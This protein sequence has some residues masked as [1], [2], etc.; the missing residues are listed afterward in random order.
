MAN[1]IPQKNAFDVAARYH[2]WLTRFA[3]Y[4]C[5]FS[6]TSTVLSFFAFYSYF[7][8]FVAVISVIALLVISFL[9]VRFRSTYRD[10]EK[11]RRDSL[12]DSS[13][14]TKIAEVEA[15]GYYANTDINTGFRKLLSAIHES[16]SLSLEIIEAMARKQEAFTLIGCAVVI[17][18]CAASS[19]QSTLFLAILN[20][21]L[22]LNMISDYLELRYLRTEIR[23]VCDNCKHICEDHCSTH[24]NSLTTVQQ[25]HVI[26]ECLRYENALAYA[27]LMF[28]DKEYA[29]LNPSHEKK[30]D[31]VKKRYYG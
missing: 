2:T 1:R 12:I 7:E 28:S 15:E 11:I 16:S 22:S 30:W 9:Q 6:I 10:A 18:A 17:I 31:E 27:S 8:N 14:G 25:A 20:G 4:A 21:F 19:L 24:R 29:K 3:L 13:F 26:R 5:F 23:T